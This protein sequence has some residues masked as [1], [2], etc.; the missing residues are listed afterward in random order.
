MFRRSIKYTSWH[1]AT[2]TST[3]QFT[4]DLYFSYRGQVF[5]RFCNM[6]FLDLETVFL[7][8]KIQTVLTWSNAASNMQIGRMLYKC[9]LTLMI[10]ISPSQHIYFSYFATCI[11][12]ILWTIFLFKRL[13][14]YWHSRHQICKLEQRSM[15]FNSDASMINNNGWGKKSKA[16]FFFSKIT[17]WSNSQISS[18]SV[19]F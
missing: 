10:C 19:G 11:S 12:L 8:K 15:H 9:I 7:F 13:R 4:D 1:N 14:Q 2:C 16:P 17:F 6:N 3:L 5:L 18:K